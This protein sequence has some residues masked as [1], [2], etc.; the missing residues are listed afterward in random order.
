MNKIRWGLIGCGDVVRKRVYRAVQDEPHSQ[1]IAA[2]RRDPNRLRAF[3]SEVGVE[4][5]YARFE[6]L[7][8]DQDVDAV[9]I[10]TPVN[11][12]APQTMAAAASG[13]HVLV[14]KPM[15]MSVAECR[16][17]IAACQESGVRLGVAYYRRF[18]PIVQR[19]QEMI[20]SGEIGE[21]VSVS[22][23]TSTA[24]P[25]D[26][27]QDGSWRA[28]VKEGGGGALM[29]IGSHRIDL[30]LGLFGE[31]ADVRG[32]C[33][34]ISM[35]CEVEDCAILAMRFASGVV[36]SLQCYFGGMPG[37]DE[38]V[39]MAGNG[40]L[41]ADPLNGSELVIHRGKDRRVESHPPAANLSAPLIADFVA[42]VLH[43]REPTVSGEDG[44]RVNEVMEWSYRNARH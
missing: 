2:C 10:A 33:E 6:D 12:H 16:R 27:S 22:A 43:G 15:A 26:P 39:V 19:I 36:G 44:M 17:M 18:Y 20:N 30:F 1:V 25:L 41:S 23:V 42:A 32:Y 3:C 40:R 4:R 13:K 29:D 37:R 24:V 28:I 8:A 14:E 7:L 9:Y 38:F 21:V 31:I 11:Q 35:D 34:T 5:A